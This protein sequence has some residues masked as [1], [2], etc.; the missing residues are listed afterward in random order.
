M[1]NSYFVGMQYST[2]CTKRLCAI[3]QLGADDCSLG[4][5]PPRLT[6]TPRPQQRHHQMIPTLRP[7]IHPPIQAIHGFLPRT[8][9]P[10]LQPQT[11]AAS[12]L[13]PAPSS[14]PPQAPL[15]TPRAISRPSPVGFSSTGSLPYL[16]CPPFGPFSKRRRGASLGLPTSSSVPL[17]MNDMHL[18]A[19]RLTSSRVIRRICSI[20]VLPR[21][22]PCFSIG[23][24]RSSS[25]RSLAPSTRLFGLVLGIICALASRLWHAPSAL[26]APFSGFC[27]ALSCRRRPAIGRA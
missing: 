4:S 3:P 16:A 25:V 7:S 1:S 19:Q 15:V 18:H 5:P 24:P 10:H 8:S 9:H 20:A 11:P 17:P 13:P 27:A 22:C 26:I 21:A 6:Y 2:Y 23:R 14:K 12:H